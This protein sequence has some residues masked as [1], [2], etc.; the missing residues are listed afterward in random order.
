VC[1]NATLFAIGDVARAPLAWLILN[2]EKGEA[3][4][5]DRF[6]IHPPWCEFIPSITLC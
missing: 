3:V 2:P 6:L 5:N 4:E 1:T